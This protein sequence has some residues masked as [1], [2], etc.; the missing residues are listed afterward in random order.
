MARTIYR[1]K[2][3]TLEK[4]DQTLNGSLFYSLTYGSIVLSTLS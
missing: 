1:D 4:E 3:T 2:Q